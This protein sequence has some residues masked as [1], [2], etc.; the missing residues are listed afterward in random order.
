[1][2]TTPAQPAHPTATDETSYPVER[3]SRSQRWARGALIG[4]TALPLLIGALTG[5]TVLVWWTFGTN[6]MVLAVTEMLYSAGHQALRGQ[7]QQTLTRSCP[8][9]S[10]DAVA[11]AQQP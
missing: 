2:N 9:C 8:I 11:A 7:P 6:V 3:A 10:L 1:M 4:A 5:W